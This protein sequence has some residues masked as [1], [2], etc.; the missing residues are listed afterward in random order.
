MK[1]GAEMDKRSG[2]L[3]ANKQ[4]HAADK[5]TQ[6]TNELALRLPMDWQTRK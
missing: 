1:E 6:A 3:A 4:T 5:Q 2:R